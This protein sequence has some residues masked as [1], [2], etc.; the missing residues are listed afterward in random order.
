MNQCKLVVFSLLLM[1]L[2]SCARNPVT[3]K[4]ELSLMSESQELA[5]GKVKDQ[6]QL[7]DYQVKELF[8]RLGA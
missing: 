1:I 8:H 2:G 6:S 3:G 4:R 5:L 7:W